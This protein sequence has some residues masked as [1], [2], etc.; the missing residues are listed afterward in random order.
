MR[1]R[2]MHMKWLQGYPVYLP[3]ALSL[4]ALAAVI[5]FFNV[6][7]ILLAFGWFFDTLLDV[8]RSIAHPFS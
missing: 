4:C 8:L 6:Y 5:Y 1:W 7:A 2:G 3:L